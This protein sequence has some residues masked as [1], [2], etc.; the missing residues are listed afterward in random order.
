MVRGVRIVAAPCCGARYA[1][2]NYMSVNFLAFE[3]WTDGWREGS[4]MP[5][6]EGLRRCQ[7]GQFVLLKNLVQVD[8]EE[9]SPL[10]SL[11]HVSAEQLPECIASSASED[12]EL[13]ARL[14]YWRNLNHA[15]RELYRQH[16]DAKDAATKA[17]WLEAR[18]ASRSW[19]DKLRYRKP[20]SCNKPSNSP[21][22][23][24]PYMPTPDQLENMAQLSDLL[25]NRKD[26]SLN[27][28]AIYLA[29]LY[30]EQSRFDEAVWSLQDVEK[31]EA[32]V[33]AKLILSMVKK[34]VSAPMRYR[35]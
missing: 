12:M 5:N 31:G 8:V 3:Y 9:R 19:W 23:Y 30:R 32:D 29:E 7:C 13:A 34:S 28:H 11:S 1:L 22:S 17:K 33:T 35:I 16:R 2:P 25:E 26:A 18:P 14:Q 6:D 4:L 10:A 27:R 15:Y 24:P 20:P 21:F